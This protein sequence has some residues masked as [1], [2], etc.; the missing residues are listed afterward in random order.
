MKIFTMRFKENSIFYPN[1]KFYFTGEHRNR[2]N[3]YEIVLD[4]KAIGD[5][6]RDDEGNLVAWV[7]NYILKK[8]SVVDRS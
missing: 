4:R 1:T 8:Y 2:N 7:D 5:W 3:Q 6:Q